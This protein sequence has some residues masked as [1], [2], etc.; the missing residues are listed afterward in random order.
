MDTSQTIDTQVTLPIELYQAIAQQAQTHGHSLS[1]EIVAL[2]T[3]L[4]MQ[5]PNQMEEEFL[6]WEAASD[7]D[8]LSMEAMLAS[9]EN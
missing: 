9:E 1:K 3:P 4:L 7:E 8:W 2:L 6:A 5:I